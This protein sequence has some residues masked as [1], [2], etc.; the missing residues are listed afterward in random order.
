M[1]TATQQGDGTHVVIGG[2]WWELRQFDGTLRLFLDTD[3]AV[4]VDTENRRIICGGQCDEALGQ[5]I[6]FANTSA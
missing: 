1:T 2:Q 5:A 4:V 6:E 3:G